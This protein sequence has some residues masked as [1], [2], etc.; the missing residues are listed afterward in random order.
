[1]RVIYHK[2]PEQS[3]PLGLSDKTKAQ[4]SDENILYTSQSGLRIG[5]VWSMAAKADALSHSIDAN[6]PPL[7]STLKDT[8]GNGFSDMGQS[9]PQISIDN[10]RNQPVPIPDQDRIETSSKPEAPIAMITPQLSCEQRQ[11]NTS[12]ENAFDFNASASVSGESL[13]SSPDKASQKA[14]LESEKRKAYRES[15]KGKAYRKAYEQSEKRKA[16]RKAYRESEKGKASKKAYE[17]SE[18]RKASQKAYRESERGKACRKA[19]EQS[20]KRKAYLKAYRAS[21]KGKASRKAYRE[22]EKG[23]AYQKAYYEVFK[24]TGNREQAKIAG[25]QATDFI[26]E[27]N[28]VKN[29]ELESISISP[30]PPSCISG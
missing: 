2:E 7:D 1:M 30:L 11:Q 24:N 10:N 9:T 20:E 18:K 16:Y 14:Y 29:S 27:S 15:E 8:L 23:K 21:E 25:K 19:H 13:T 6:L 3:E 12:S 26:R 28:K 17:Q 5:R 4:Q 22:S